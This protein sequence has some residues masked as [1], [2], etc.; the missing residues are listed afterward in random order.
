MP[1]PTMTPARAAPRAAGTGRRDPG[2]TAPSGEESPSLVGRLLASAAGSPGKRA[3]VRLLVAHDVWLGDERFR[4]RCIQ[5]VPSETWVTWSDVR[6]FLATTR[7]PPL[8]R[9]VLLL[10]ADL[11]EAENPRRF[12]EAAV[13]A[14][15][16]EERHRRWAR[17][18]ELR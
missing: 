1:D 7:C 5:A 11:A 4:A 16:D 15:L 8:D 2:P 17:A 10:A 12:G 13:F 9:E 6:R 14:E 3:A 18:I